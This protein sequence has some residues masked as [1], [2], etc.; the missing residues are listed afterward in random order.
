MIAAEFPPPL[1]ANPYQRLLAEALGRHELSLVPAGDQ[2][3]AR[4]VREQTR[5]DSVHLHWLEALFM[6]PGARGVARARSLVGERQCVAALRAM[7]KREMPVVWTAHNLWPHRNTMPQSY[8][9]VRREVVEIADVIVCHSAA[10]AET[11]SRDTGRSEGI[12]F[13]PH[14]HYIDAYPPAQ[15]SREET[16]RAMGIAPDQFVYLI[17]GQLRPDKRVD[18][19]IRAVLALADD[20]VLI[21][22]GLPR[23]MD[24]EALVRAA[25]DDPRVRLR[26]GYVEDSQIVELHDASDAVVLNHREIF[27]SGA[28]VLALSQARPAVVPDSPTV[29]EIASP[30]AIEPFEAG[31]LIDALRRVQTGDHDI[32]RREALAAARACDWDR[33]ATVV[34]A[35]HTRRVVAD[36]GPTA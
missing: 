31:G 28:L 8:R 13:A 18:E 22:A 29:R 19:V 9:R 14:G 23:G 4:W 2:P 17:A 27:T 25:G 36:P 21:V 33:L 16:R 32:R 3:S 24:S 7:Q 10:A 26:L 6:R 11:L 12:A 20:S 5:A 1:A 15:R 30:P 35:A 34:A